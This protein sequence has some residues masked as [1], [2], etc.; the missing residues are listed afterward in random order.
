MRQVLPYV[1]S[2]IAALLSIYSLWILL[3][4]ERLDEAAGHLLPRSAESKWRIWMATEERWR[5]LTPPSGLDRPLT[6]SERSAMERDL[7]SWRARNELRGVLSTHGLYQNLVVTFI[8]LVCAVGV[9]IARRWS[10]RLI[11]A[12]FGIV[13]VVCGIRMIQLSYFSSLGW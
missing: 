9:G 13:A 11:F 10:R 8:L 6:D 1:C 12:P 5:K 4:V 2:A 7:A 3:T